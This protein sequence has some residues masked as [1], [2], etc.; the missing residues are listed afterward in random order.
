M[1]VDDFTGTC[2]TIAIVF[3]ILAI[4]L[5]IP[6]CDCRFESHETPTTQG[7]SP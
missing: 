3:A 1:S 6:R 2:R 5:L 4:L 7:A